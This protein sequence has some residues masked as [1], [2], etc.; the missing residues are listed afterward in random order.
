MFTLQANKNI[1]YKST[2][3]QK[4]ITGNFPLKNGYFSREQCKYITFAIFR[5]RLHSTG[6]ILDR[7]KI[8]PFRPSV[9]TRTTE[10]DKFETP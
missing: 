6:W 7:T 5:P 2:Q 9:Y 4:W 10:P 1:K 8:R 3:N